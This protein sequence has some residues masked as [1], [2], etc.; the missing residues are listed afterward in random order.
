M[1]E[2]NCDLADLFQIVVVFEGL[3]IWKALKLVFA[4]R[5]GMHPERE[6]CPPDEEDEAALVDARQKTERR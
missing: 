3:S 5:L 1:N 4:T 2:L 6:E